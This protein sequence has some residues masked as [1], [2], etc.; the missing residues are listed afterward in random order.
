VANLC[1][2]LG[3]FRCATTDVLE[4][5]SVRNDWIDQA[6]RGGTAGA[7]RWDVGSGELTWGDSVL[8]VLGLGEAAVT[9][10]AFIALLHPD[11]RARVAA[12]LRAAIERRTEY[13]GEYRLTTRPGRWFEARGHLVLEDGEPREMVGLVHDITARKTAEEGLVRIAQ[14]LSASRQGDLL[15]T[16]VEQLAQALNADLV[17]IAIRPENIDH[18]HPP[19]EPE[20]APGSCQAEGSDSTATSTHSEPINRCGQWRKVRTL[21]LWSDGRLQDN[22]EYDLLDTPCANVVEGQDCY[23]P[24]GAKDHFERDALLQ[25]VN[26]EGYMGAPIRNHTGRTIGLVAVVWR[27]PVDDSRVVQA[28][29]QIFGARAG[30][31]IERLGIERQQKRRAEILRQ[32]KQALSSLSRSELWQTGSRDEIF[33][34]ICEV[35]SRTLDVDRLSIWLKNETDTGLDQTNLYEAKHGRHTRGEVFLREKAPG[36]FAS[37]ESDRVIGASDAHSDPRTHELS[38]CCLGPRGIVSKLDAPIRV[39]GTMAGV[40][41]CEMVGRS[42]RW[43]PEEESFSAS[44]ADFARLA[45]NLAEKKHLQGQ[46]LQ[47]LA[48]ESLGR[49][50]GG[51]AHDFNN[52]LTAIAGAAELAYDSLDDPR[53]ATLLLDDIREAA[54]RAARLTSQLLGFARKRVIEPRLVDLNEVIRETERILLRLIGE[55]VELEQRLDPG[56]W[57]AFVD[58]GQFEQIL[59][60]LVVN[61]RDAMPAGGR[62]VIETRNV[63]RDEATGE[64]AS[65]VAQPNQKAHLEEILLCISD[66]GNGIAPDALPHI[67]EPFFTTKTQGAGSGLGLATT[68]GVVMQAGGRIVADSKPGKGTRITIQLPRASNGALPRPWHKTVPTSIQGTEIL[69]LVEDDERVRKTTQKGLENLGY[70]VLTAADPAAA[71]QL[72]D[73]RAEYLDLVISD[74]VMPQMSGQE[75]AA[76]LKQRHPTLPVL[77]VSGYTEDELFRQGLS[78]DKLHFVAK[79]FTPSSLATKVRQVLDRPKSNSGE[80]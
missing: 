50:A 66:T 68:Y 55:H 51:V 35:G 45:I 44:L 78:E 30:A 74:V 12:G 42:R 26:A 62:I 76:Q 32:Q 34:H 48:L 38:R 13:V 29:V 23:Y 46:L 61:A 52:L 17:A 10:E 5:L 14:R 19:Q 33:Q 21:A 71:L 49:L 39:S 11:D 16:L 28:T 58:P 75:M 65:G 25:Q 69:L 6:L 54:Q 60:N 7:W 56:L 70:T 72:A 73:E 43:L 59:V 63:A 41:C 40:V 1:R 37:L 4:A 67:F 31:E 15:T 24:S 8:D 57:K 27:E 36:Y 47:K 18:A 64:V 80:V 53:N 2:F 20:T 79:P 9:Y 22:I 3:S 77:F